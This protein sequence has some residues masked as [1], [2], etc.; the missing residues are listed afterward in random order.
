MPTNKNAMTRYMVLDKLLSNRYHNYTVE[1]LLEKVNDYL[2]DLSIKPIGMRCLEKDIAYLKGE[3]SPF[4]AEIESYY[5]DAYNGSQTV[6]KRC[7]RYADPSFSIFHKEMSDEEEYLLSQ[8]LSLLGQFDGLPNLEE[9]ERL[10]I[11]LSPKG[12]R[13]I[14]SF[15]KNPLENT[16]LFAELF[17]AIS[18]K[19]V[20]ELHYHTFADKEHSLNLLLHPYLLKEYN[21]RWYLFGIADNDDKMLNFSLDRIDAVKPMPAMRYKEYDGQLD[22]WF[23][24]I[25][26]VTRYEDRPIQRILFWVSDKSKDY[27][28]TKPL[29]DS[30]IHYRGQEEEKFRLQHPQL[31]GGAYFSI[32]CI[33][34]YELLRELTSFGENLIVLSPDSIRDKIVERIS[35]MSEKYSKTRT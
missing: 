25:I 30:Q 15:T 24:D 7:L 32:D 18:Q 17:T 21:R 12:M 6:R 5:K 19:Q 8:A 2:A 4:M 16:T 23:D 9:L 33:E 10:R 1:E 20:I 11:G 22:E 3:N 35:A 31:Q 26:G 27:V 34:N 13:Q 14:V 29:H 28:G